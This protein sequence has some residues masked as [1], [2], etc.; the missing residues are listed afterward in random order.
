MALYYPKFSVC[1]KVMSSN[2][3][4]EAGVCFVLTT[5]FSV[6]NKPALKFYRSIKIQNYQCPVFTGKLIATLVMYF[7]YIYNGKCS[8]FFFIFVYIILEIQSPALGS[9]MFSITLPFYRTFLCVELYL[10]L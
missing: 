7:I 2:G 10:I 3:P 4:K 1:E 9:D 8:L 5:L 6:L